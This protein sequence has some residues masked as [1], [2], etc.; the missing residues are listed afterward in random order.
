M[1]N[2]RRFAIVALV[3]FVAALGGVFVGRVLV[4][5]LSPPETELHAILHD[6][7]G[8]DAAQRARI[9]VLERQFAAR[10]QVLEQEMRSDNARL[11][12]AITAEHGYGPRVQA[13]VDRSHQVMGELQKETLQ[14][15]F[16]L[17][18]VLRPDQA[19]KFDEAAVKALTAPA[20]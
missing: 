15:V 10:K 8:L 6:R 13:A 1:T 12:D 4:T 3:A 5:R 9:E 20:E 17:R 19:R 7:L 16:R 14:H 11:A 18:S 2:V